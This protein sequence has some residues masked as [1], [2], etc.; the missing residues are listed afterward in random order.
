M[1]QNLFNS[2]HFILFQQD[3][4]FNSVI[5]GNNMIDDNNSSLHTRH[6]LE[7]YQIIEWSKEIP[8]FSKLPIEDRIALLKSSWNEL[9][10]AAFSH[11]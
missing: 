8:Y 10:I 3:H 1:Y 4:N 11:R 2:E 7:C 9:L 5:F 6:L